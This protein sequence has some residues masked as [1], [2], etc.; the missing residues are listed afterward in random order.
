MN[1]QASADSVLITG[2]DWFSRAVVAK[3]ISKYT[4]TKNFYRVINSG[5]IFPYSSAL[6]SKTSFL[7]YVLLFLKFS[8]Q[9]NINSFLKKEKIA[10]TNSSVIYNCCS[11]LFIVLRFFHFFFFLYFSRDHLRARTICGSF[12]GPF[13]IWRSFTVQVDSLK[14]HARALLALFFSLLITL[15][16]TI[17]SFLPTISID[18]QETRLWE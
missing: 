16:V 9:R 13:G 12:W 15:L 6:K 4:R 17:I 1:T 3:C 14:E 5:V 10:K 7:L 18:C 11:F 8:Q 2:H